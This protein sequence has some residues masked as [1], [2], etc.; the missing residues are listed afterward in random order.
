M[1]ANIKFIPSTTSTYKIRVMLT[2]AP[3]ALV[4]EIKKRRFYIEN[5]TF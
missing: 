4:K 5:N 3:G 1:S 2:G